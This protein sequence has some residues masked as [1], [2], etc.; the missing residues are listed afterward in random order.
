ML[1][2]IVLKDEANEISKCHIKVTLDMNDSGVVL[3]KEKS[4]YVV[5]TKDFFYIHRAYCG[6]K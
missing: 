1:R 5:T 3:A 2:A 4:I 6:V